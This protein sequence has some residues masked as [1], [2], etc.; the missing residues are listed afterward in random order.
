MGRKPGG[1]TSNRRMKLA[2]LANWKGSSTANTAKVCAP[3]LRT[4]PHPCPGIWT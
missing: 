2:V 3:H 1:R 4:Q